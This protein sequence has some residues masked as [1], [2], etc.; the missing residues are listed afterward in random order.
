VRLILVASLLIVIGPGLAAGDNPPPPPIATDRPAVTDSSVVVPPG[1]LQGE[2]GF[3]E[4]VSQGQR[5]VDGP[6]TLLRF[7]VASKT[8]LRLTA[9]NHF[10]QVTGAEGALDLVIWRSG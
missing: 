10:S 1:S 3:T 9:P 6:E 4:T 8:E 5:S 2:N 7:G